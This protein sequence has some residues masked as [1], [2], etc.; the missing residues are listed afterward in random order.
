MQH[1][2]IAHPLRYFGKQQI[3]SHAVKIGTEIEIDDAR[4]L[5]HDA[6]GDQPDRVMGCPLRTITI[7]SRLEVSLKERL[8]YQLERPLHHAIPYGRDRQHADLSPILGYLVLPRFHGQ[9]RALDQLAPYPLEKALRALYLDRLERHAVNSRRAVVG[10]RKC[11][12]FSERFHFA[13]V[14]IDPPATPGRFSLR[15]DV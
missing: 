11:I 15:L 5:S 10:F 13:D 7:R 2:R 6:L 9:V 4:L 1:L 14:N 3:V 8:Q 12:G